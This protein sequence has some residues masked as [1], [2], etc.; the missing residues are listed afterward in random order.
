MIVKGDH[1]GLDLLKEG[2]AV[3]SDG[4]T[5]VPVRDRVAIVKTRGVTT[6]VVLAIDKVRNDYLRAGG[7][8][9]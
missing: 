4:M 7:G 8:L 2:L 9:L 1:P 6:G 3:T 5:G